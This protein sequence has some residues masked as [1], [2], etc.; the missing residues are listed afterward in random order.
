MSIFRQTLEGIWNAHCQK[1][2]HRDLKPEN[3]LLF[4]NEQV[5]ISDFGL[6]KRLDPNEWSAVL[7]HTSNN[8]MGTPPYA[9][10]EQFE[11]FR[12]VDYRADI[13]ALGKTLLHMVIGKI[14][15]PFYNEINFETLE[16]RYRYLIQRCTLRNPDERFQTVDEVIKAFEEIT[17]YQEAAQL[18]L[19]L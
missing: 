19:P 3:I 2:I 17:G 16:P 5:K 10:P 8:A 1:V 15:P 18:R 9:A 6:C 14:P 12:D 4:D 7:T 13:Y 11:S